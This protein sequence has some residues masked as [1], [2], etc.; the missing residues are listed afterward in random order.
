MG[1]DK[2][3][4]T[5]IMHKGHAQD[6]MGASVLRFMAAIIAHSKSLLTHDVRMV[7]CSRCYS[8]NCIDLVVVFR[9]SVVG[10]CVT[11]PISADSESARRISIRPRLKAKIAPS[12]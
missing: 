12:L 9:L 5:L 1:E 7:R 10:L 6:A 11:R 3:F 2:R 4:H 8:V